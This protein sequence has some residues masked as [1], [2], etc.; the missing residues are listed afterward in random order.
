[1]SKSFINY[2]ISAEVISSYD[3]VAINNKIDTEA[4]GII[5]DLISNQ[6]MSE[7]GF[8]EDLKK[9]GWTAEDKNN[10]G[11]TWLGY[12]QPQ[13][14]HTGNGLAINIPN[15]KMNVDDWIF[16]NPLKLRANTRYRV[17]FYLRKFSEKPEL[18]DI[19]LGNNATSSAM[20][21]VGASKIEAN[22]DG[23]YHRYAYELV[24]QAQ[25]AYIGFAHKV[26]GKKWLMLW[27]WMMLDLSMQL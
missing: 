25:I 10:N 12:T 27:L 24:P 23:K 15:N 19:Y 8:E 11:Q 20:S 6:S 16:S 7:F 3:E 13:F 22:P 4:F 1:M 14:A 9:Y 21:T 17:V 2:S 26:K 5:S 18:L